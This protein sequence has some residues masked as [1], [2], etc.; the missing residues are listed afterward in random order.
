MSA[1]LDLDGTKSKCPITLSGNDLYFV[2]KIE[3]FWDVT[4]RQLETNHK[5][6]QLN[7]INTDNESHRR[8]VL[9]VILLHCP[10]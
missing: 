5:C 3:I 7:I 9:S 6:T 2:A 1:T 4:P 8:F 10:K